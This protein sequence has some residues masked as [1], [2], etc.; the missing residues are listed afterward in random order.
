MVTMFSVFRKATP[1]ASGN[2]PMNMT[3]E[4]ANTALTNA[5]HKVANVKLR[6]A[7]KAATAAANARGAEKNKRNAELEAA[8]NAAKPA[9]AAAAAAAPNKPADNQT[10]RAENNV[11]ANLIKNIE[12]GMFNKNNKSAVNRSRVKGNSKYVN[13]EQNRINAAM[14]ARNRAIAE[15]AAAALGGAA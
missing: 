5:L 4:Q 9:A 13:V 8:L 15:A 14:N 12:T 6:N 10:L 3:Q 11:V 7:I 2:T 1:Q